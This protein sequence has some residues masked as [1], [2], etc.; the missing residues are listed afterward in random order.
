MWERLPLFPGGFWTEGSKPKKKGVNRT[1]DLLAQQDSQ[2]ECQ[3]HRWYL[4]TQPLHIVEASSSFSLSPLAMS[5][6]CPAEGC[7]KWLCRGQAVC[8]AHAAERKKSLFESILQEKDARETHH[9]MGDINQPRWHTAD[10]VTCSSEGASG[11]L[12]VR[13]TAGSFVIK[14]SYQ[15]AEEIFASHLARA[16]TLPTPR[17]RLTSYT[18]SEWGIIKEKVK[19]L[20]SDYDDE[21]SISVLIKVQKELDRPVLLIIEMVTGAAM[22]EGMM[23]ERAQSLLDPDQADGQRRLQQ[24]GQMLAFDVF[25]NN[26]DRVPTAVW[27]NEGNGRN[28]LM[29]DDVVAIDQAVVAIDPDKAAPA[30]AKYLCRARQFLE[31]VCT[32][33]ENSSAALEA[34]QSTREFLKRETLYDVGEKGCAAIA[35][36]VRQ[37][38]VDICTLSVEALQELKLAV[39][40]M[41]A[42]DWQQVFEHSVAKINLDFLGHVLGMYKEV[43]EA[44][45]SGSK[46]T[47]TKPLPQPSSGLQ[48]SLVQ[49]NTPATPSLIECEDAEGGGEPRASAARTASA[50]DPNAPINPKFSKFK[51]DRA[52]YL[53][54]LE[55]QAADNSSATTAAPSTQPGSRPMGLLAAIQGGNQQ[56]GNQGGGHSK[57]AVQ[58]QPVTPQVA[59][60]AAVRSAGGAVAAAAALRAAAA[61]CDVS[62]PRQGFLAGIGGASATLKKVAQSTDG[63]GGR[64]AAAEA[65]GSSQLPSRPGGGFL[66]GI[67]GPMK[68]KKV[69]R[70][71]PAAVTASDKSSTVHGASPAAKLKQQKRDWAQALAHADSFLRQQSGARRECSGGSPEQQQS[72]ISSIDREGSLDAILAMVHATQNSASSLDAKDV[73]VAFDFDQTL[74]TPSPPASKDGTAGGDRAATASKAVD[75]D[76]A[77]D[78]DTAHTGAR[79]RGGRQSLEALKELHR[80]G[81]A[82][83][84]V[85]AA[86]PTAANALAIASEAH[87]LGLG[88]AFDC[89]PIK[90]QA[91]E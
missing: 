7:N 43:Q 1:R 71:A 20:A 2:N 22:L 6:R 49:K 57:A 45:L 68:L 88:F 90:Q 41:V 66:A 76:T 67:G 86:K 13:T 44:V 47:T 48:H 19:A 21:N 59:A 29:T 4:L 58:L 17:V 72:S 26:S 12:F 70:P 77:Q 64:G 75:I 91:V 73:L 24:V 50:T 84:V 9:T 89:E 15:I 82:M 37:G 79:L 46:E 3:T 10:H 74:T 27:D 85:T 8:N 80:L 83:M 36:G 25:V 32:G 34:L 18:Q 23:P 11:V 53:K 39:Q 61:G 63:A 52:A 35:H 31:A 14:G 87:E 65:A 81:T 5:G 60:A 30:F 55:A 40:G 16:L 38:L 33:D 42:V 28:V 54:A 69:V 51:G 78:I 56:G 62:A